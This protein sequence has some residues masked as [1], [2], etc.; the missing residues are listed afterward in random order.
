MTIV[1]EPTRELRRLATR[2]DFALGQYLTARGNCALTSVFEAPRHGWTLSNLAL[3]HAEATLVL[4][5]TDMALAP[6]GWVA[7]RAATETA[8]KC[9]W[10]LQPEDEWQREARWIALLRE[11]VLIRREETE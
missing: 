2:I 5:K 10:L 4:A 1:L 3:R 6:T 8:A 7:A 11:G 9:L